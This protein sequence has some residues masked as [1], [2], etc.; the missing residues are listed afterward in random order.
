M[1]LRMDLRLYEMKVFPKC[2]TT[3][4][5]RFGVGGSLKGELRSSTPYQRHRP[6]HACTELGAYARVGSDP[7]GIII[8]GSGN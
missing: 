1:G 8:S 7:A 2:L 6:E 3:V 4:C 5:V